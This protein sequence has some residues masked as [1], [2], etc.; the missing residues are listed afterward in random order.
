[1]KNNM[2]L[3][4]HYKLNRRF[5]WSLHFKCTH[6]FGRQYSER[7]TGWSIRFQ[8]LWLSN[9]CLVKLAYRKACGKSSFYFWASDCQTCVSSKYVVTLCKCLTVKWLIVEL[10]RALPG[11]PSHFA[12]SWRY[13]WAIATG[14]VFG[15]SVE[16]R[17]SALGPS[18]SKPSQEPTY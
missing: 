17:M 15:S 2:K 14:T 4:M 12:P 7:I 8:S 18:P 11:C 10:R 5:S 6:N 13:Q 3:H 9:V 1:M 16:K